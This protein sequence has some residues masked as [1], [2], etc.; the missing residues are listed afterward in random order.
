M[1]A[2]VQGHSKEHGAL[3]SMDSVTLKQLLS[4]Y[5]FLALVTL[6]YNFV[7]LLSS[8]YYMCKISV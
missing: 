5:I 8:L 2:L 1:I 6:L 7:L 4:Q 3:D